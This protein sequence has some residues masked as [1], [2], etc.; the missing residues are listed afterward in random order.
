MGLNYSYDLYL[1]RTQMWD[2]LQSVASLAEGTDLIDIILPD[3]AR[4]TLPF[5][6]S[7]DADG[8]FR[9][10]SEKAQPLFVTEATPSLSFNTSLFFAPDQ[11]L[12]EYVV[13]WKEYFQDG[14]EPPRD[15][16]GRIAIGYVYLTIDL[17]PDGQRNHRPELVRFSF[18]AA[19][20]DM[21]RLFERSGSVREAFVELLRSHGGLCGVFDDEEPTRPKLFWPEDRVEGAAAKIAQLLEA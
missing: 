1:E 11:A 19:T 15:E 10:W 17:N 8:R 12:E 21:S 7:Y 9:D 6:S 5:S 16:H 2:A 4:L 20:S 18:S 14:T 3:G 13:G